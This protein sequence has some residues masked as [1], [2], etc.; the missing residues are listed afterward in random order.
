MS[1]KQYDGINGSVFIFM[2][3]ER[4]CN[5]SFCTSSETSANDAPQ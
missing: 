5:T 1:V 3:R 4:T 2:K